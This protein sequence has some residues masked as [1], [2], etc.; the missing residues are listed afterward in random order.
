MA[1]YQS[2]PDSRLAALLK[3]GDEVAYT[4]IFE[5]YKVILYKH[6][7]RV[8][9]DRDDANDVI[10]DVFLALWQKKDMLAV[11]TSLGA[12]LYHAVRNR[13]FDRISHRKVVDK[14]IRSIRDFMEAGQ[15]TTDEAIRAK[16]LAAIIEAEVAALPRKMREVF[17]LSRNE[18]LS[19]KE[20]ARRLN[21]SDKTVK[22]QVYNAVKIL[23]LKTNLIRTFLPFL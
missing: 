4:E 20:I 9:E 14:Y 6:A 23:R 1:L 17:E 3:A 12:Y 22:Q 13:I 18:E 10:Q 7:F 5:R 8:L 2:L 19:Y 21:I 11:E 15:Y 16:E